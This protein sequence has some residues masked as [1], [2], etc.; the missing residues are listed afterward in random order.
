MS[1]KFD[2][3]PSSFHHPANEG[4]VGDAVRF[5]VSDQGLGLLF[6]ERYEEAPGGLRVRQEVQQHGIERFAPEHLMGAVIAIGIAAG[7]NQPHLNQVLSFGKQGHPVRNKSDAD[8]AR[9]GHFQ[10]MAQKAETGDIGAGI[11]GVGSHG[12]SRFPVEGR[13]RFD[14]LPFHGGGKQPGFDGGGQQPRRWS[15]RG[16]DEPDRSPIGRI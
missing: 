16:R 2:C 8:P 7:G 5:E 6:R 1:Y 3:S 15:R 12:F 11:Y 10:G 4:G 9:H 14:G 13:H